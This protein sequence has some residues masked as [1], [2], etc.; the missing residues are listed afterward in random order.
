MNTLR[1][2][3]TFAARTEIALSLAIILFGVT[4]LLLI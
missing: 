4:A 1:R 3:I 2:I